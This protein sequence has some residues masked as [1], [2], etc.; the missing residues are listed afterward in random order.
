MF[1]RKETKQKMA[2]AA[3]FPSFGGR[4]WMAKTL[5]KIQEALISRESYLQDMPTA[6]TNFKTKEEYGETGADS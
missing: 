4:G 3:L 1:H 5:Q 2:L 6:S